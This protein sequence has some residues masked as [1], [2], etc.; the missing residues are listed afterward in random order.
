M[1]SLRL[2]MLARAAQTEGSHGSSTRHKTPIPGALPTVTTRYAPAAD[3]SP[4][5][6]SPTRSLY[7]SG[8]RA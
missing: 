2:E 1:Q 4:W 3:R 6:F 7:V 5:S 8:A